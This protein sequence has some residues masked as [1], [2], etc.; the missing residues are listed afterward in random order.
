M[1][2][3]SSW[4][5]FK[6]SM[7]LIF[8][9]LIQ[10]IVEIVVLKSLTITVDLSILPCHSVNF[11]FMYF[12]ALLLGVIKDTPLQLDSNVFQAYV[13]TGIGLQLPSHY[14]SS[15]NKP[16]TVFIN[17]HRLDYVLITGN[18]QSSVAYNLQQSFLSCSCY[19]FTACWLQLSILHLL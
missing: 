12:E 6:Y 14:M 8:C 1:S 4:L 19:M 18:L 7:P 2:I 17:E 11:H 15:Y 3:R 10:Q 9:L 13:S 5:L 16:D